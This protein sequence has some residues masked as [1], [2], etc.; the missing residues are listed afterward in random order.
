MS[1]EQDENAW[2]GADEEGGYA[3][4]SDLVRNRVLVLVVRTKG[5]PQQASTSCPDQVPPLEMRQERVAVG[6]PKG[7]GVEGR[8]MGPH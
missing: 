5:L 1:L 7:E 8:A 6:I 4:S 2:L 3:V